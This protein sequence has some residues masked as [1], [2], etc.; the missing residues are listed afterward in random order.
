MTS[1]L[2]SAPPSRGSITQPAIIAALVFAVGA[3]FSVWLQQRQREED[4]EQLRARI[5]AAVDFRVRALQANASAYEG[6][7]NA[8]RTL[9]TFSDSVSAEEFNGAARDLRLRQPGIAALELAPIV[10]AEDRP[11]FERSVR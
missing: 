5:S 8:L 6:S 4:G 7:M 2:P 1:P 10:G 3:G 11:A 9:F